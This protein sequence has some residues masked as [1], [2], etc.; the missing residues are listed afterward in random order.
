M[1]KQT[2]RLA[3][4]NGHLVMELFP[5]APQHTCLGTGP[6]LSRSWP[7]PLAAFGTDDSPGVG[8]KSRAN[9]F[10]QERNTM[11]LKISAL[12]KGTLPVDCLPDLFLIWAQE[13]VQTH[14]SRHQPF[15]ALTFLQCPRAHPFVLDNATDIPFYVFLLLDRTLFKSIPTSPFQAPLS[16]AADKSISKSKLGNVSL[17]RYP[18]P[19]SH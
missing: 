3:K 12:Q 1:H 16:Q 10:S 8:K 6:R 15:F 17:T 4:Q 11:G 14:L 5:S 19:H 18:G 9:L 2:T 7:C 13:C